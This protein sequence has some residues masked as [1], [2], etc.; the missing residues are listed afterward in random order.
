MDILEWILVLILFFA[1]GAGVMLGKA[2]SSPEVNEA[3]DK[4]QANIDF[5]TAQNTAL[6]AIINRR[7]QEEDE[8]DLWEQRD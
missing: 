6:I 5:L 8:K 3:V 7:Y 2:L 1:F 4:L